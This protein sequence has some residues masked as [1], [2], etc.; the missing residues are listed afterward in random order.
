M[1]KWTD[2]EDKTI[3]TAF[4]HVIKYKYG[5]KCYICENKLIQQSSPDKRCTCL[6]KSLRQKKRLKSLKLLIIHTTIII[7]PD[8]I[9]PNHLSYLFYFSIDLLI[10]AVKASFIW[11]RTREIYVKKF[12]SVERK[13]NG[14]L[15]GAEAC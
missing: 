11:K 15:C 5:F 3:F 9:S 8:A 10:S 12:N 2:Y 6:K 4:S 1:L 13:K 7:Y 14:N